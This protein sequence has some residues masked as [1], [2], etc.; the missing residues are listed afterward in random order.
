MTKKSGELC[1]ECH[2][3][4][5][6]KI[7][8]MQFQHEPVDRMQCV[9]CH[10]A[11]GSAVGKY[12]KKEQPGLC[13]SCH[14]ETSQFWEQGSAH[15]PAK[16]DCSLCHS[17]HGS[18]VKALL[19]TAEN[20]LCIECHDNDATDFVKAHKG[21]KARPQSCLGCHD[22]HGGPD[23]NLL[24]PISHEPFKKGNCRPCHP[25]GAK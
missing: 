23:K 4:E 7:K 24:Y 20:K 25:G 17:P 18:N 2:V 1:N 13:L 15:E 21:I 11:H 16:E 3:D 6:Q 19:V 14:Q 8:T 10:Q 22:P 5:G 9:A 12:L